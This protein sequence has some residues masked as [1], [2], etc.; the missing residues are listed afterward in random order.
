MAIHSSGIE[1]NQS[2][3]IESLKKEKLRK[4]RKKKMEEMFEWNRLEAK[5][6]ENK[7]KYIK[8]RE[9]KP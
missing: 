1:Q 3:G 6:E 2:L 4:W 9:M 7:K 5:A 8:I